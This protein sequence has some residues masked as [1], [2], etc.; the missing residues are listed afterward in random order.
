[1]AQYIGQNQDQT[2]EDINVDFFP[3]IS[4]ADFQLRFQNLK[5]IDIG[6]VKAAL[7]DAADKVAHH[8]KKSVTEKFETF[9]DFVTGHELD[10][11]EIKRLYARAVHHFAISDILSSHVISS[12]TKDVKDRVS[13]LG[14]RITMHE[15]EARH[16]ISLL[17]SKPTILA[18]VV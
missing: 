16:A 18:R 12:D 3:A 5:P 2:G 9:A 15:S 10:E 1:M 4:V 8:L 11:E 7:F 6:V 14:E 17:Q 13:N